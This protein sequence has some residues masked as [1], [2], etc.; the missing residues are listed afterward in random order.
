[1]STPRFRHEWFQWLLHSLARF[2]EPYSRGEALRRELG[3]REYWRKYG[4]GAGAQYKLALWATTESDPWS[5][6]SRCPRADWLLIALAEGGASPRQ[7]TLSACDVARIGL[8]HV[9]KDLPQAVAALAAA[10]AWAMGEGALDRAADLAEQVRARAGHLPAAA[11]LAALATAAPTD[12]AYGGDGAEAAHA[13]LA[14]GPDP[15]RVAAAHQRAVEIVLSRGWAPT[16]PGRTTD[17]AEPRLHEA[18]E[19]L[20][21]RVHVVHLSA[22]QVLASYT[23]RW[24]LVGPPA[25]PDVGYEPLHTAIAE[26]IAA[27]RHPDRMFRDFQ[28]FFDPTRRVRESHPGRRDV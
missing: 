24:S 11:R 21:Q 2:E 20:Q 22:V 12:V 9:P 18:W 27:A 23:I 26:R 14:E 19:W 5:A 17:A 1:M 10:E 4:E 16:Q 7:R 25:D 6:W 28:T 8:P 15:E 13:A 3:D